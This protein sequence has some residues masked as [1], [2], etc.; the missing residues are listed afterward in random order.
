[1]QRMWILLYEMKYAYFS[2][3]PLCFT[4]CRTQNYLYFTSWVNDICLNAPSFIL[5]SFFFFLTS[6]QTHNFKLTSK[7]SEALYLKYE[8]FLQAHIFSSF[9]VR[10]L[11]DPRICRFYLL[12]LLIPPASCLPACHQL[13]IWAARF[14]CP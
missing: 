8:S 9:R 6:Y 4:M 14:I 2:L 5:L 11:C 12:S 1:M 3:F 13:C 10:C 7:L